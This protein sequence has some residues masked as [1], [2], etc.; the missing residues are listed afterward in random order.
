MEEY[1]RG[2]LIGNQTFFH[3][4]PTEELIQAHVVEVAMSF[5]HVGK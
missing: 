4:R 1:V 5:R 3:V 2:E